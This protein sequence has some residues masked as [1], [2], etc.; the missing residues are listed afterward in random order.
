MAPCSSPAWRTASASPFLSV[1]ASWKEG[2]AKLFVCR[3]VSVRVSSSP[4]SFLP[5]F[6]TFGG[7]RAAENARILGGEARPSVAERR[8][9]W[10]K[11]PHHFPASYQGKK[12]DKKGDKERRKPAS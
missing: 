9:W 3:P 4:S 10:K 2:R 1:D 11:C 12:T 7:A 6:P 5:L 8:A